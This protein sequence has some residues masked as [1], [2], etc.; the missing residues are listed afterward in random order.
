MSIQ[1]K[2]DYQFFIK[3]LQNREPFAFAHFNDGEMRYICNYNQDPISR[4]SQIYHPELSN[5]LKHALTINTPHTNDLFYRGIPCAVCFPQMS[6]DTKS[7]LD[8]HNPYAKTTGA[9]V[10]HHNY[11]NTENRQLFF[12]VLQKY[13]ITWLTNPQFDLQSVCNQIGLDINENRQITIP[14]INA[15]DT[16]KE[17]TQQLVFKDGELVLLLCG[18]VGRILAANWIDAY[19]NTT[20]LCI[21]SYFDYIAFGTPHSYFFENLNCPGCCL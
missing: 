7:L 17:S 5:E 14:E 9:C 16:Y 3:K 15:Y 6:Q 18:P 21:G 19:P 1:I 10:F 8:K 13:R 2:E 4:G 12:D 20:F 11:W